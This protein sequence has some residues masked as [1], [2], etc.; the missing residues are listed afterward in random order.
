[1]SATAKDFKNLKV[2]ASNSVKEIICSESKDEEK[3]TPLFA[4][5]ACQ[6]GFVAAW[7]GHACE[8][9]TE[10][11]LLAVLNQHEATLY[12]YKVKN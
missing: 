1:M 6:E 3:G 2:S 11:D 8:C 10:E 5:F 7:E 4:V 12:R 9:A